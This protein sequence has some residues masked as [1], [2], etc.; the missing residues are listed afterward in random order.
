MLTQLTCLLATEIEFHHRRERQSDLW[1]VLAPTISRQM[2]PFL[3]TTNIGRPNWEGG[4][5][6]ADV[7]WEVACI[8][9]VLLTKGRIHKFSD[10]IYEW[11]PTLFNGP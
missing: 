10:I 6:K 2:R 1:G 9:L 3:G 11:C 7:A 4:E 8:P 5:L